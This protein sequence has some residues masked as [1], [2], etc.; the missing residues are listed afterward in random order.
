METVT[1][2]EQEIR[3]LINQPRKKRFLLMD[4]VQWNQLCSSMDVIGDTELAIN[5]YM[6]SIDKPA[7]TGELYVLLYGILQVLFVQQ[8]AVRS[9]AEALDIQFEPNET[10]NK[11]RETRNNS[12]GHPTKRERGKGRQKKKWFNFI[13]RMSMSRSGF[14]LMTTYPDRDATF[15]QVDILQ[16]IHEQREELRRILTEVKARLEQ[17]AM[18]HKRQFG[19][20]KLADIF[21][22]TLHYFYEKVTEAIFGGNPEQLGLGALDIIVGVVQKFR[23]AIDER[24]IFEAYDLGDDFEWTEYALTKI[25]QYFDG[26]G[27]P[28]LNE[29]DAYIYLTF[30]RKKLRDLQTIADEID[31]DYEIENHSPEISA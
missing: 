19:S 23:D 18:E 29:K 21:P 5:A 26:T 10:L 12:V 30:V 9:L 25:R 20:E 8:D 6:E 13:T 28:S 4:S 1:V 27:E 7:S 11:I 17:E 3:D 15:S 2:L 14:T 31:A 22:E 24:Q 16:L